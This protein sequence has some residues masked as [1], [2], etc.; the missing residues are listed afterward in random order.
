MKALPNVTRSRVPTRAAERPNVRSHAERGNEEDDTIQAARQDFLPEPKEGL[1]SD[2]TLPQGQPTVGFV[3]KESQADAD[4]NELTEDPSIASADRP[5]TA[6]ASQGKRGRLACDAAGL[7]L[8]WP[9]TLGA[10]WSAGP[11]PEA[12]LAP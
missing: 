9:P 11:G 5:E 7:V 1:V 3:A 4:T 10:E 2:P 6:A 12:L 8:K